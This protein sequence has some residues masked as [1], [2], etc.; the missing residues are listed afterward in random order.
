MIRVNYIATHSNIQ[1]LLIMLGRTLFTVASKVQLCIPL[2]CVIL[3]ISSSSSVSEYSPSEVQTRLGMESSTIS[4]KHGKYSLTDNDEVIINTTH[5]VAVQISL[6]A[7]IHLSHLRTGVWQ[8][9][10]TR[11]QRQERCMRPIIKDGHVAGTQR[12]LRD[13]LEAL[14]R[15]IPGTYISTPRL[16]I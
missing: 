1:T 11:R 12:K 4:V 5:T 7:H 8:K 13:N 2:A 14:P 9:R 3:I 6:T 10:N 15:S 16:Q